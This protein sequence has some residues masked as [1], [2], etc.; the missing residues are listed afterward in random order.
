[1]NII[2][3][4]ISTRPAMRAIYDDVLTIIG[5]ADLFVAD[6]VLDFF[7]DRA[8]T[9]DNWAISDFPNIAPPFRDFF[10]GFNRWP[11]SV[12]TFADSV[13][14]TAKGG[15][16]F[17]ARGITEMQDPNFINLLTQEGT[18]RAMLK[19][20]GVKWVIYA[21]PIRFDRNLLLPIAMRY[22]I[23]VL[24]DGRI[25]LNAPWI[26]M[27]DTDAMTHLA[28]VKGCTLQDAF[29]GEKLISDHFLIPS[30]ITISMLHCRNVETIDNRSAIGKV[31][32]KPRILR[33]GVPGNAGKINFKTIQ[34]QPTLKRILEDEGKAEEV[35]LLKALHTCRGHFKDYRDGA[36]LFGKHKELYWWDAH[37]RGDRDMGIILK[38]YELPRVGI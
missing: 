8:L 3:R 30:L 36:G 38:D 14:T 28:R 23:S 34:I 29:D 13:M 25:S 2:E 11:K 19:A 17:S 26:T 12:S 7:W 33:K 9:Q 15:M 22:V 35:G 20:S 24:E 27:Y 16:Y 32:K 4:I 1:M 31:G 6:N 5:S 18:N 10:V 37:E 21:T